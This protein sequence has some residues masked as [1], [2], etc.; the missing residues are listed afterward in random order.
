MQRA[1]RTA[2]VAVLAVLG[3]VALTGCRTQPTVAAYVGDTRITE[4]QVNEVVDEV[5]PQVDKGSLGRARQ[6]VVSWLVMGRVA[7]QL[8]RDRGYPVAQ[9][10]YD[11][12]AQAAR[13]PAKTKLSRVYGDLFVRMDALS[14]K[15]PPA[16]PTPADLRA[17]YEAQRAAGSIP[18]DMTYEQA[19]SQIDPDQIARLVGLRNELRDQA[20]RMHVSVNPK[21]RPLTLPL[22]ALAVPLGSDTDAL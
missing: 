19:V 11:A 10:D 2:L 3:V 13:L 6:E 16:Q 18:P 1:R 22:G 5:K 15:L 7:D 9:P 21:Y 8:V 4:A 14:N 20:V 17:I 12:L